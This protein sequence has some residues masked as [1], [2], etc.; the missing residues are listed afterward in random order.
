MVFVLLPFLFDY[1]LYSLMTFGM[2]SRYYRD[3]LVKTLCASDGFTVCIC[4]LTK[5][6]FVWSYCIFF[7]FAQMYY[8]LVVV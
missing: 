8:N 3:N 6:I 5:T 4:L 7:T 2:H 1:I